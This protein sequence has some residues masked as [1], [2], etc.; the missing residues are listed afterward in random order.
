MTDKNEILLNMEKITFPNGLVGIPEWKNFSISQTMDMLPIALL[1]CKDAGDLSLIV[2]NPGTW[3]PQY[4]FEVSDEDLAV[5]KA[6]SV[7]NLVTLAIINVDSDPFNVTAN[8]VS[9][10]LLNP[11]KNLGV[12]IVLHKSQYLVNQPLTLKT[13]VVRLE[14]G[15]VGLPEYKNFVL[16]VA[17]ELLPVML[18]VSQDEKRISFPVIDPYLINP[19][20]MP[21]LEE[22]E[23]DAIGISGVKDASWFVILNVVNDPLLVTANLM[24]PLAINPNTGV[25][26]QVI[27]SRSGYHTSHPIRTFEAVKKE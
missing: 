6:S 3:Y 5:V 18:L 1:N 21:R 24:A 10:I 25:G 16:Q 22:N 17:E 23:A 2:A 8:L 11:D 9:P 7:D 20:Y 13:M 26:R 15:L 27:L 19:D 12:Q 14:E 4:V